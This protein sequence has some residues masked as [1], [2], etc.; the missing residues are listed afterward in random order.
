MTGNHVEVTC[1]QITA[2]QCD[3]TAAGSAK[4]FQRH[5]NV[6]LRLRAELGEL[7]SAWVTTPWFQHYRNGKRTDS[8][9]RNLFAPWA[10][11]SL[12]L[13]KQP[14]AEWVRQPGNT[15]WRQTLS[16]R[17]SSTAAL[18]LPP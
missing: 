13:P 14:A 1:T 2:T 4:G 16:L 6:T 3:F 5:Y 8:G 15:A 12:S 17:K 9:H 18:L 11:A 7:H 10:S